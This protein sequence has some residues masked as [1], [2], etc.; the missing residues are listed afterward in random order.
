M[1]A[2]ILILS[3]LAAAVLTLAIRERSRRR[4]ASKALEQTIAELSRAYGP[5]TFSKKK[6]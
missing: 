1:T 2:T 5:E 6:Q 4:N 3:T